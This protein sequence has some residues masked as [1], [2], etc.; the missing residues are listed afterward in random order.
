M[1]GVRDRAVSR[2][3]N[4]ESD[5]ARVREGRSKPRWP[6]GAT[7]GLTMVAIGCAGLVILLYRVAGPRDVF[8]P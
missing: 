1:V 2:H 7:A 4:P 8:G 3:W 6:Q 5:L